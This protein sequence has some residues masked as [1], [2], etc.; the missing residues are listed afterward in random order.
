MSAQGGVVLRKPLNVQFKLIIAS[1]DHIRF[2]HV[3]FVA[4]E[5]LLLA[6]H[7]SILFQM[8]YISL[9]H[10][11]DGLLILL[12]ETLKFLLDGPTYVPKQD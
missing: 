3:R 12:S 6:R 8:E 2:H 1:I 4:L 11:H 7:E 10:C 9:S 5:N